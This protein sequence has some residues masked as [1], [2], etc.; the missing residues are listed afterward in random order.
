M[1]MWY[2][3]N[4]EVNYK[5]MAYLIFTLDVL[6]FLTMT[7]SLRCTCTKR[8]IGKASKSYSSRGLSG[9]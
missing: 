4:L 8:P 6:H 9:I 7:R 1:N 5:N 2:H 3:S